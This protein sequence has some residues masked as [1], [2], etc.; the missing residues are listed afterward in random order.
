MFK[1]SGR[2]MGVRGIEDQECLVHTVWRA[3]GDL[4]SYLTRLLAQS[5]NKVSTFS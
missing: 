3:Q 4:T 2:Q 5:V 1:G